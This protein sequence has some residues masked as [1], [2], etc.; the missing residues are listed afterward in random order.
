MAIWKKI[1][2]EQVRHIW[3]T[4]DGDE[5]AVSPDFYESNGTPCDPE[6]GEDLSYSHT[7]IMD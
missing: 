6:T 5:V 4:D 3:L 7:E 2:D 1:K